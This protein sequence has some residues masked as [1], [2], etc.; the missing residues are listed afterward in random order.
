MPS[1]IG[2]GNEFLNKIF[3]TVF[4]TLNAFSQ[5]FVAIKVEMT[6]DRSLDWSIA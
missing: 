2:K 3:F 6:N 4:I 5:K 1:K